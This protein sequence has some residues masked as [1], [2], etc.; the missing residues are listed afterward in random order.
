MGC[1]PGALGRVSLGARKQDTGRLVSANGW[2][3]CDGWRAC[4]RIARKFFYVWPTV[5]TILGGVLA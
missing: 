5:E 3:A 1:G 4:D 2:G